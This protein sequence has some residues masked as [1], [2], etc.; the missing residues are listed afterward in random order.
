[1]GY[2]PTARVVMMRMTPDD[3]DAQAVP[4]DLAALIESLGVRTTRTTAI[5]TPWSTRPKTPCL[6]HAV[7]RPSKLRE[8]MPRG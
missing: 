5:A 8:E 7:G 6:I 4:A 3:A 1:M 2:W